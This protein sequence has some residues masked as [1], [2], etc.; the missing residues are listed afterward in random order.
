MGVFLEKDL[1]E[2]ISIQPGLDLQYQSAK[3]KSKTSEHTLAN[4][5]GW[6]LNLPV[7]AVIKT[8]IGEG[9]GFLGA[10]PYLGFGL[11]AK[12]GGHNLFK[13]NEPGIDAGMRRWDYGVGCTF[14]YEFRKRWQVAASFKYGFLDL[15]KSPDISLYN[16]SI[17]LT[18]GYIL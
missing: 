10:G 1:S 8:D 16:Q 4:V 18:L 3:L 14:G 9:K 15:Y 11:S 13:N 7:Y 2:Y 6:R 12:S 5:N 17:A